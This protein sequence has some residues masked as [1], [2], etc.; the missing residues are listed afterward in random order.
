MGS[1]PLQEG[2]PHYLDGMLCAPTPADTKSLAGVLLPLCDIRSSSLEIL[3]GLLSQLPQG[4]LFTDAFSF[5]AR[6]VLLDSAYERREDMCRTLLQLASSRGLSGSAKEK[7]SVTAEFYA[8][9]SNWQ[10]QS[11]SSAIDASERQH[12]RLHR[13][14]AKIAEGTFDSEPAEA[15][16]AIMASGAYGADLQRLLVEQGRRQKGM[17]VSRYLDAVSSVKGDGYYSHEAMP[18]VAI[19]DLLKTLPQR[20]IV[21]RWV[22]A[23]YVSYAKQTYPSLIVYDSD[24]DLV[25]KPLLELDCVDPSTRAQ[26]VLEILV[27][28]GH[29]LPPRRLYEL[30]GTF[31]GIA[32]SLSLRETLRDEMEYVARKAQGIDPSILPSDPVELGARLVCDALDHVDNRIRWRALH[33]F[34]LAVVWAAKPFIAAIIDLLKKKHGELWMSVRDWLL[35]S[36]LNICRE[37]PTLVAPHSQ[38][39]WNIVTDK[40]FPHAGHQELAKRI[41]VRIADQV[42]DRLAPQQVA[43]LSRI[44]Q[45]KAFQSGEAAGSVGPQKSFRF[46]FD[47]MDTFPYW[48]SY[49]GHTFGLHRC[50]VAVR[51]EKWICDE[52]GLSD[53]ACRRKEEL[54]HAQYNWGLTSHDHGSRPTVETFTRYV[55]LHAMMM[56][57]GEMV[58]DLP[59]RIE[60]YADC[61]EDRWADWIGRR[62]F[63]A[64]VGILSDIRGPVPLD[65]VIHGARLGDSA[66]CQQLAVDDFR[67][68]FKTSAAELCVAGYYSAKAS[69]VSWTWSV[70]TAL[71]SQKMA[72]SLGLALLGTRSIHAV[73][74]PAFSLTEVSNVGQSCL[75]LLADGLYRIED[76]R[77]VESEPFRL[78][79]WIVRCFSAEELGGK[80]PMWRE[81]GRN[82][83]ALDLNAMRDLDLTADRLR[84]TYSDRNGRQVAWCQVWN[85]EQVDSRYRQRDYSAGSR[86][87]ML[88]T[89]VVDLLKQTGLD[90]VVRVS[91]SRYV[92]RS[93]GSDQAKYESEA[94]I[95]ILR[96]NGRTE[97][98]GIRAE[99]RG[100]ADL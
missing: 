24:Y 99:P 22:A 61:D 68:V 50:D 92:E 97:T 89:A 60:H 17:S 34:R 31:A 94:G 95:F 35:F 53:A 48:Y 9:E 36:L 91:I 79:P 33:A 1:M 81:G 58:R 45:P 37:V 84:L 26:A 30:A 44:N 77:F 27:E 76:R 72:R 80:D 88:R 66:T 62:A 73:V 67:S 87:L 28:H 20:R 75:D 11:A 7:L 25:A 69:G 51:A 65:P 41:L 6:V 40:G 52:W 21:E 10:R 3:V 82:W 14:R 46:H 23:N 43:A 71:V 19:A 4:Q 8:R 93:H 18:A 54:T 15:V 12:K 90:L 83:Y 5:L 29:T 85:D 64:D 13:L 98:V 70:D 78:R 38:V 100:E 2:L 86:L 96:Q 32:P 49:L 59:G 55:E 16:K 63:A 42:A 57:A 74:I 47:R 39:L 56:A